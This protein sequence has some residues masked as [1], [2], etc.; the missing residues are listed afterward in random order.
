ME[1]AENV[2]HICIHNHS[3]MEIAAHAYLENLSEWNW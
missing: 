1:N 3:W 2:P